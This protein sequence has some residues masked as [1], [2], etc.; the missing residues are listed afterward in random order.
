MTSALPS[1][2]PGDPRARQHVATDA[3]VGHHR[4]TTTAGLAWV[5][6]DGSYGVTT[7]RTAVPLV[8]ELSA[9]AWAAATIPGTDPLHVVTDC[10]QG[11]RLLH[12]VLRHGRLDVPA[13]THGSGQVAAVCSRIAVLAQRRPLTVSWVRGHAGDPLNE[14]ADRL[15]VQARRYVQNGGRLDDIRPLTDRI[16]ADARAARPAA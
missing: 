12:G 7:V 13:G 14:T 9:I 11:V 1:S 16:A 4:G 10:R 15:A 3:S 6:A 8:A 2:P 5:R